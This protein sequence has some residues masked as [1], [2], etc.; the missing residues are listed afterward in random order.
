MP[1]VSLD[2]LGHFFSGFY[3][4]SALIHYYS[5]ARKNDGDLP[6]D[7]LDVAEIDLSIWLLWRWHGD[8]NDL[9]IIDAFLDAFGKAQPLCRNVAM[10]DLL[11]S[12]LINRDLSCL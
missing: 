1:V 2:R 3:R 10:D 5:I 12:G 9:R 4:N 7:L 6:C 8:K 11:E